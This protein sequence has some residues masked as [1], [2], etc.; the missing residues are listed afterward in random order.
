[1]EP[2]TE[3]DSRNT[4]HCLTLALLGLLL[5]PAYGETQR[6]G[7]P[8]RDDSR[9]TVMSPFQARAQI[10]RSLGALKGFG[11]VRDVKISRL[12]VSFTVGEATTLSFMLAGM[13]KLSI[14]ENDG[15]YYIE[16][17]RKKIGLTGTVEGPA[18]RMG[19]QREADAQEFIEALNVLRNA[20]VAPDTEAADFDS[21]RSAARAWQELATRPPASDE[22]RTYRL[23]AEEALGRKDFF[24]ALSLYEKALVADAMWAEGHYN[25]AVL[26]EQI[27][28]YALAANHMRRYL[29]LAPD[30]KDASAARDL[31]LLW[32]YKA[33]EER[34]SRANL[35]PVR[36]ERR[37]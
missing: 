29:V 5:M 35:S 24:L 7:G 19:F 22:M 33:G 36:Q 1:M 30:A 14:D 12:K 21:F 25:A 20:A 3:M 18:T 17:E 6:S 16:S 2:K 13:A 28:D 4:R 27:G 31:M 8:K 11:S 10:V 37:R 9:S 34:D 15:V 23:V 32:Q 26:S